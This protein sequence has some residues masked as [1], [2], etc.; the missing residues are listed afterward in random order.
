MTITLLV[1]VLASLLKFCLSLWFTPKN[2]KG[3][4]PKL[5]DANTHL[6]KVH[7]CCLNVGEKITRG[8]GANGHFKNSKEDIY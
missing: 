3:T 8:G 7:F 5:R 6:A 1:S 4:R 2:E